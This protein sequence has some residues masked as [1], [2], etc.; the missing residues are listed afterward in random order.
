MRKSSR[1]PMLTILE[2]NVKGVL[3]AHILIGQIQGSKR[4]QSATTFRHFL[5]KQIFPSLIRVLSRLTYGGG[6]QNH[7]R[8]DEEN[9][10]STRLHD[11]VYKPK[12]SSV[13]QES[14][15]YSKRKIGRIGSLDFKG[16]YDPVRLTDYLLKGM[17]TKNFYI[18]WLASDLS[19]QG[20]GDLVRPERPNLPELKRCNITQSKVPLKVP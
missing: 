6:K 18:A 16:V 11:Q 7:L 4:E 19:F 13:Q 14:R 9:T 17:R 1:I 3:H 8:L 12:N 5:Q 15:K 10:V 20:S 2:R